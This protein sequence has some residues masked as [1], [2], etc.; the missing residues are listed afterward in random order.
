MG[1]PKTSRKGKKAWRSNISTAEVDDYLIHTDK[2][3][4][5]G[6]PLT[7]ISSD[8][9][10]YLDKSKDFS[11][12]RKIEKYRSKVL[13]CDSILQNSSFIAPIPSSKKKQ[14]QP[15]AKPPA[16]PAEIRDSKL[17]KSEEKANNAVYDIWD[18]R[19]NSNKCAEEGEEKKC[20]K[21]KPRKSVIPAV[22]VDLPGCSYNPPFEAHQDA[23]AV[24]VAEEMQKVYKKELEPP[25]IPSLV[26][27]DPVLEEDRYFLDV[28]DGTDPDLDAN[29][30]EC[31]LENQGQR[32]LKI[33]KL[34]QAE[35]NRKARRQEQLKI[36]AAKKKL[37]KIEKDVDCL[38]NI[39]KEIEK[40]DEERERRRLR[41]AVAKQERLANGPP[42]LGRKK[43]EPAPMQVLLSEEVTGSLRKLKG[44][45]T[46]ARD[47]FKSLQ[48]R[49]YFAPRSQHRRKK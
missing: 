24:A 16:L 3:A 48:K 18:E 21:W 6:G 2:D 47:R 25:P 7:Q 44:C 34:T 17:S 9:L 1:V 42:R 38:P 43:F 39:I 29:N 41:R 13:H 8:S 40:E 30:D 28:D 5:S 10:F 36:E 31:D 49:G 35:L 37:A 19:G 46:L 11:V 12:K 15:N 26:T 32:P 33:R 20:L 22:E 4:R 27:G 23:L 14:K 45:C